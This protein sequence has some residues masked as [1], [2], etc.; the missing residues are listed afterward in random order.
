MRTPERTWRE[1]ASY[2]RQ[3]MLD[4]DRNLDIIDESDEAHRDRPVASELGVRVVRV[5]ERAL[6]DRPVDETSTTV[7]LELAAD[8]VAIAFGDAVTLVRLE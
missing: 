2:V 7:R 1:I 4:S 5:L 3:V 8:S 6:R